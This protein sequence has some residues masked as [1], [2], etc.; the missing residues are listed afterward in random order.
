MVYNIISCIDSVSRN[1]MFASSLYIVYVHVLVLC[2]SKVLQLAGKKS[3]K[4]TYVSRTGGGGRIR[5]RGGGRKSA[6]VSG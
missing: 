6:S 4:N 2:K 5:L 3:M 1:I